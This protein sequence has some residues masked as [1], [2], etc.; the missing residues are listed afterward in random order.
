MRDS[1]RLVIWVVGV[2][3]FSA[4]AIFGFPLLAK[5]AF[6]DYKPT[7]DS[8]VGIKLQDVDMKVYD[9]DKLVA[10]ANIGTVDI[11]RDRNLFDFDVIQGT[12][13]IGEDK[14]DFKSKAASYDSL[15][16]MLKFGKGIQLKS[17]DFDLSAPKMTI[18][19]HFKNMQA[20]GPL[21]G[22]LYA[23]KF[24]AA[25]VKYLFDKKK[26][27]TG[28]LE[29]EGKLP[30][31]VQ[32]GS[33]APAAQGKTVWN[34]QSSSSESENGISKYEEARATDGDQLIRAKHVEYERKKDVLTATGPAYYYSDDANLVADKIIV[35]R[36]ERRVL[37]IGNVRM[38][39]KP[40]DQPDIAGEIPP[41]R[42]DVPENIVQNR[43]L[44]PSPEEASQQKDLDDALRSSKTIRDYPAL[45]KAATITYWYKKG[46]RRADISGDP[47]CLQ[48]FPNGRWR[49]V[50]ASTA[51]YDGEKETLRLESDA[52]KREAR[53]KTSI[54]DNLMA[55]WFEIST[56]EADKELG[57]WK[58]QN[59]TGDVAT[60]DDED[61]PTTNKDK[62]QGGG[63]SSGGG[64]GTTGST[65]TT[66]GGG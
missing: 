42:P 57:K 50:F 55:S 37:L 52:G 39:I 21:K 33:P 22:T 36:K 54:G 41:F 63:Q 60:D 40:E 65:G 46:E 16:S 44:A 31:V 45:V 43:P 7:K 2:G 48:D 34:I 38:L 25:S 53:L 29:W 58:G 14:I 49:R 56:K 26:M 64:T 28:N 47:E 9:K 4:G 51:H 5:D 20:P 62:N 18:D 10:Q 61:L 66:Q 3:A 17:K 27:L 11:G 6:G 8:K 23:G 24:S 13:G 12:S 59:V 30:G 19:D 1:T 32:E 35:F 15:A